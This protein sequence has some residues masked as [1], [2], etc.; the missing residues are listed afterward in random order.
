MFQKIQDTVKSEAFRHAAKE[1][2]VNIATIVVIAVATAAV[3]AGIE[4]VTN[5]IAEGKN[6][7]TS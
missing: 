2:A 1:V 3:K 7:E 6:I 4:A 5:Q